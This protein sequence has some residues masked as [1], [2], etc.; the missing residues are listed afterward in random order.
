MILELNMI[1]FNSLYIKVSCIKVIHMF[2]KTDFWKS[3]YILCG[4][5]LKL[6]L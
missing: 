4:S 1:Y 2:S 6:L 3:M 5:N